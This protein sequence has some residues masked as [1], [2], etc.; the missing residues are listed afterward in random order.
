MTSSF[1]FAVY[2]GG[3]N[4]ELFVDLLK[5]MMKGL[6]VDADRQPLFLAAESILQAEPAPALRR[7]LQ[8]Q[9]VAVIQPLGLRGRFGAAYCEIGQWGHLAGS[10]G[11]V[12]QNMPPTSH[13][14]I[15]SRTHCV[16]HKRPRTLVLRGFPAFS[17]PCWS[18][19]WWRW[20]ESNR[21]P[22]ALHPQHYMLSPP[23]D[24]IPR[25]HGWQ[26]APENQ[27]ALSNR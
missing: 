10:W 22:E 9:P 13:S 25:Q 27:P 1:W 8:I 18:T 3:L 23:L 19:H 20:A 4:G 11:Q 16:A 14:L 12:P 26:S 2:S 24:L 6:W 15:R 17:G 21:R 7:Q 5:R